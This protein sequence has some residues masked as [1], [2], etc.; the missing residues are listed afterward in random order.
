M[1]PRNSPPR[2]QPPVYGL[3][4]IYGP[5]KNT[6]QQS[7]NPF[8][9]NLPKK[10]PREQEYLN[11]A[12]AVLKARQGLQPLPKTE[13]SPGQ[14]LALTESE[15][16]NILKPT[17]RLGNLGSRLWHL[18]DSIGFNLGINTKRRA[19]REARREAERE[20]EREA[21]L[22]KLLKKIEINSNTINIKK[23]KDELQRNPNHYII[24]YL[25]KSNL[26]E[27]E[28]H[29]LTVNILSN[30]I[31]ATLDQY[32]VKIRKAAKERKNK[33]RPSY[34]EN[35]QEFR[36]S[37]SNSQNFQLPFNVLEEVQNMQYIKDYLKRVAN[38]NIS[39]NKLLALKNTLKNVRPNKNIN[40]YKEI[41]GKINS[42]NKSIEKAKELNTL[43]KIII[44]NQNALNSNMKKIQEY[45]ANTIYDIPYVQLLKLQN[46]L[47][48][49]ENNHPY[50]NKKK[51]QG[52]IKKI[53]S[54]HIT[55]DVLFT[56]MKDYISHC[57]K[58]NEE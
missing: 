45:L 27:N 16:P 5:G 38:I 43:I 11:N 57:L 54:K 52:I 55:P 14:Y 25:K 2:N 34:N 24:P 28:K 21:A 3:N 49:I 10:T 7:N 9:P 8:I 1:P 23:L 26:S 17:T 44:Q 22:D 53:N 6:F 48:T 51:F 40:R 46:K 29:N 20:A 18:G 36:L 33:P 56:T 19:R 13:S 37:A 31:P 42:T 58:Y 47:S 15:K 30:Y 41:I 35:N 4:N 32:Q 50:I 12:N 39:N